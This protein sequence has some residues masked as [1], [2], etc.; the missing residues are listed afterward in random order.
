MGDL[1]ESVSGRYDT[2]AMSKKKWSQR[3]PP[4]YPEMV[5]TVQFL[6][7][8]SWTNKGKGGLTIYVLQDR[9]E[10]GLN[11]LRSRCPAFELPKKLDLISVRA[12]LSGRKTHDGA[13][14]AVEVSEIGPGAYSVVGAATPEPPGN[15][16][17][18]A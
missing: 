9:E 6:R 3:R 13:W 14:A 16:R 4:Q 7:I 8:E 11:V 5:L 2:F 12:R 17:S 15:E 10:S 1:P 18:P